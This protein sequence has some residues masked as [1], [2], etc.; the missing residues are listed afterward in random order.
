[1]YGPTNMHNVPSLGI[2]RFSNFPLPLLNPKLLDAAT[3]FGAPP[4]EINPPKNME[5]YMRP[6]ALIGRKVFTESLVA[7]FLIKGLLRDESGGLK[8]PEKG[9]VS[10][11]EINTISKTKAPPKLTINESSF[12]RICRSTTALTRR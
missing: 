10:E 3:T 5:D 8:F 2:G 11:E 9:S 4:T 7:E 6:R 1:M 12:D